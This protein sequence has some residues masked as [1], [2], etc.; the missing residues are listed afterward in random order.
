[1]SAQVLSVRSVRRIER[2]TGQTIDRAWGH[3]GY[4]FDFVTP[5]H[6]HGW[7]SRKTNQWGW[8]QN[9]LCY[10]SCVRYQTLDSTS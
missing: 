7:W 9:P 8:E 4:V 3:G 5:Q 2:A 10:T 6:R 1:M